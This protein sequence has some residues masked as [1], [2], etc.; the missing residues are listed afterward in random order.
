[1][2]FWSCVGFC[3]DLAEPLSFLWDF[4]NSLAKPWGPSADNIFQFWAQI[5]DV[6][7]SWL[8]LSLPS[9]PYLWNLTKFCWKFFVATD[10][11]TA[12]KTMIPSA[13]LWLERAEKQ[14]KGEWLSKFIFK[15]AANLRIDLNG[16][17]LTLNKCGFKSIR[18]ERS[19]NLI[20]SVQ[21][22]SL[23][24]WSHLWYASYCWLILAS[25]R[26]LPGS[27]R[28]HPPRSDDASLDVFKSFDA[29]Y[30]F[31]F[32]DTIQWNRLSWEK[33][34]ISARQNGLLE[35][36]NVLPHNLEYPLICPLKDHLFWSSGFTLNQLIELTFSLKLICLLIQHLSRSHRRYEWP[37][38]RTSGICQ[39]KTM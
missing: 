31:A 33:I 34:N 1:M 23:E 21:W 32:G 13:W 19:N 2:S 37:G 35:Q 39:H 11:W 7:L 18:H 12:I 36:R 14:P 29:V 6:R 3:S 4:T 22:V 9:C 25:M 20:C 24:N 16:W 28:G 27:Y 17:S 15:T 30:W 10:S 38:R 8:P 5:L 26:R